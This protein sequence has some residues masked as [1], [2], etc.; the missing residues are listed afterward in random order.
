MEVPTPEGSSP[1]LSRLWFFV[2]VL[3]IAGLGSVAKLLNDFKD[4]PKIQ[5]RVWAAYL[6]SG[7][8][9]GLVLALLLIDAYGPSYLLIGV[10]GLAGFQSVQMLTWG[11]LLIQKFVEKVFK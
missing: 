8:L 9:A 3:A 11:A 4:K 1:L 6:T 7:L 10:A 5:S 2:F